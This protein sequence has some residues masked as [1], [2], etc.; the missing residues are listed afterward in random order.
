[1]QRISSTFPKTKH[2]L[3]MHRKKIVHNNNVRNLFG[4]KTIQNV[5]RSLCQRKLFDFECR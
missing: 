2:L 3:V 4:V 1:M 5:F